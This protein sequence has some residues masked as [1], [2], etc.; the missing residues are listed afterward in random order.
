MFL[1]NTSKEVGNVLPYKVSILVLMDVPPQ[2]EIWKELIERGLSFNPCFNGCSSPTGAV[3][4]IIRAQDARFN[5]CFN[6]C[7]SPTRVLVQFAKQ[8]FP[9]QS[10]F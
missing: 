6:G 7:S 1:T 3:H 2:H 9:F 4:N 8:H 5:P 10:L